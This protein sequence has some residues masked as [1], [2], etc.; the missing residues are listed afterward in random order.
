MV[1]R[2]APNRFGPAPQRPLFPPP[3]SAPARRGGGS[4]RA[5]LQPPLQAPAQ[6]PRLDSGQAEPQAM[7]RY[8]GVLPPRY[9]DRASCGL[10][11]QPPPRITRS[12]APGG[13]AGS[14][15]GDGHSNSCRTHPGTIPRHSRACRRDR[16]HS[17]GTVPPV[18]CRHKPSRA[19][20]VGHVQLGYLA[21]KVPSAMF[22][23]RASVSG[24]SPHWYRLVVPA[25]QAYSHSASVGSR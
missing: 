22:P 3:P 14:A 17:A 25:R 21:F 5:P 24:S 13:P 12:E 23:T 6:L 4:A 7:F 9:A 16:R 8:P 2:P 19:A 1:V 11:S 10:L 20:I 15:P 18:P